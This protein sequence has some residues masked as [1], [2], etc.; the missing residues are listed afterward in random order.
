MQASGT[1]GQCSRGYLK[2]LPLNIEGTQ[3]WGSEGYA[4]VGAGSFVPREVLGSCGLEGAGVG[5]MALPIG[6]NKALATLASAPRHLS[7]PVGQHPPACSRLTQVLCSS[8]HMWASQT[9]GCRDSLQ[10]EHM[11]KAP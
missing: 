2:L 11:Q 3:F 4:G 6:A 5:R 1:R 7:V 8:K 10:I 9:L